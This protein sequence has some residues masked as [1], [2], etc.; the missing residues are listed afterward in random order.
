[1]NKFPGFQD[2]KTNWVPIPSSFFRDLL[3]EI[4]DS[5]ELKL[6]LYIFWR[7]EQMEGGF[8]YFRRGD[9]IQ[10]KRFY[11]SLGTL[12]QSAAES[13]DKAI[14]SAVARGWLLEAQVKIKKT[15]TLYFLNTAR[16]KAAVQAIHRGEWRLTDNEDTP[17]ALAA[18][19]PNIYRLYEEHIG[20]L[21]PML[22]DILRQAE[23]EF[24]PLW[25][26]EAIRIAVENNVR[27]WRYVSAILKRWKDE[28]KDERKDRQDTEKARRR[29]FEWENPNR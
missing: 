4:N 7:L 26:E 3:P 19:L 15:E 25:I 24:S 12:E 1:M 6:I 14:Q 5:G 2:G 27:N 20:P 8:R 17:I 16:G 22:A 23:Q 9:F 11:E 10:D 21:T 29:Y 28:G 13:L 18:E